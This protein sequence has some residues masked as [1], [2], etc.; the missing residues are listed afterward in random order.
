MTPS[1]PRV[2]AV[3]LAYL[4]EPWVENCVRALLASDA[5]QADVIVV[6][7][8]CTTTAVDRLKKM[9]RVT[10]LSPGRNLGFAGGCNLGATAA[11]GE[12]IALINA[13]ALV[14]PT[15]LA[16]LVAVAASPRVG[17]ASGS[18]RLADAPDRL[19][20]A[21]NPLHFLGL[22]WA[23]AFG[24]A[25]ADHPA[26]RDV[27]CASGAAMML[28][29]ELWEDLGGFDPAYFAYLEDAEMSWRCW[30]RGLRVVYVAGAVVLHR[31]EFSRN[32][33]KLYLLERNRLL[34][35]S[36]LYARRTL[37]LL[38]PALV[39]LEL[40]IWVMAVAGGW[41][42]QKAAGWGWLLR[43]G[44]WLRR[45]RALLQAQRVVTYRDLAKLLTSRFEPANITSPPGVDCVNA[46]LGGYWSTVRR[47]L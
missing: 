31:Y 13:D 3:V 34:L 33:R 19:N 42:R 39:A 38:L 18:I 17:I 11:T 35:L 25:A 10:V 6:D 9:D 45:R 14:E 23:G 24:E 28:R 29:R 30:Q 32:K 26:N 16:R 8:G 7:N 37:V 20:S 27:A 1:A 12:F 46:V 36:T 43:H 40:G 44:G 41:A 2:S 5:V 21:G 15:A 47:W 4:E 22:S